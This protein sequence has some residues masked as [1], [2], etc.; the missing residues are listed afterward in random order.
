MLYPWD[1]NVHEEAIDVELKK[2]KMQ[3]LLAEEKSSTS[4]KRG[5]LKKII[6]TGELKGVR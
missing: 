2:K 6:I 5:G 4:V 1:K 3:C